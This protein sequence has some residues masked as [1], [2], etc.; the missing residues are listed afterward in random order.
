MITRAQALTGDTFHEER[1]GQRCATWRRNG[2]SQTWKRDPSRFRTP[3]K[4]GLYAY[5]QLTEH[6]LQGRGF[7]L[8]MEHLHTEQECQQ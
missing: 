2:T 5:G 3:V 1:P 7:T 8:S 6:G 4:F